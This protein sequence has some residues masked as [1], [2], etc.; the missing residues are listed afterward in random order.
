MPHKLR[1]TVLLQRK[2]PRL[3]VFVVLPAQVVEPWSLTGTTIIEGTAN[4]SPMGR[5]TIKAWG[6]GTGD[7]FVEF[8]AAFCAKAGLSVGDRFELELEIAD[9][10]EPQELRQALVASKEL[11]AAWS[12]LSA[13]EKRNAA[14][15]IRSAKTQQTRARRVSL[16]SDRLLKQNRSR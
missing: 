6:K 15:H 3:P 14:E 4:G 11:S 8:T 12:V 7:W 16:L 9:M 13:A 2:D 1:T 5:R 10:S